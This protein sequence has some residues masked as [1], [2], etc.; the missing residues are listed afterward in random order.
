M[1]ILLNLLDRQNYMYRQ[2]ILK[3]LSNVILEYLSKKL[4]LSDEEDQ[5]M[6]QD[7]EM[8]DSE[9]ERIEALKRKELMQLYQK[10]KMEFLVLI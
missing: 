1:E 5:E 8:K 2:A 10:T 6:S 3:V 7:E 9:L 4:M